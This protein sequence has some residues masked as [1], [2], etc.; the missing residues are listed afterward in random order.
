MSNNS[1]RMSY[2]SMTF[3]SVITRL[4]TSAIILSITAL[5]TPG[6]QISSLWTLVLAAVVLTILDY[7]VSTVFSI[8]IGTL[9]HGI[10][11]FVVSALVLYATQF[12]VDGYSISFWAAIIGA[13]IYGVVAAIIPG[14]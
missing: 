8:K 11:G 13:A 1:S 3:G 14:R 6:F 2:R 9:G 12:F 7:L 5:F 4:I 10:I